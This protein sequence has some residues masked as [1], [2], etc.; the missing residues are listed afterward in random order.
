MRRFLN[1]PKVQKPSGSPVIA[2]APARHDGLAPII[3]HDL[4][5]GNRADGGQAPKR[6]ARPKKPKSSPRKRTG[7]SSKGLTPP[8]ARSDADFSVDIT[9][10]QEPEL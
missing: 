8:N 10:W 7:K 9:K 4:L 3:E 6:P 5:A 2:Y 1:G